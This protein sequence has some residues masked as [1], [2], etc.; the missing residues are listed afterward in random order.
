MTVYVT[1]QSIDDRR[2]EVLQLRLR[3]YRVSAMAEVLGCS[4][5]TIKRDLRALREMAADADPAQTRM[6]L[7]DMLVSI[8]EESRE[9]KPNIAVRA[10]EAFAKLYGLNAPKQMEV[11]TKIGVTREDLKHLGEAY[12]GASEE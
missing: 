2:R 10:V 5:R 3:N 6:A 12:L 1:P 7:A 11:A 9:R 8:A 4:P